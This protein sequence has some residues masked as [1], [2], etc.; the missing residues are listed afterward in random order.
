MLVDIQ[1]SVKGSVVTDARIGSVAVR[2]AEVARETGICTTDRE[3]AL[4][5]AAHLV[6]RRPDVVSQCATLAETVVD[7]VAKVDAALAPLARCCAEGIENLSLAEAEELAAS[8][9]AVDGPRGMIAS[10]LSPADLA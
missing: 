6:N 10:R 1:G 8:L 9:D 3:A 2:R 7:T 5:L 4:A